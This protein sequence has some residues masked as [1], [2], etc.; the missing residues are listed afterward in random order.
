MRQAAGHGNFV[1]RRVS[2][3]KKRMKNSVSAVGVLLALLVTGCQSNAGNNS[4]ETEALKTQIAQLEQQIADLERELAYVTEGRATAWRANQD[5][6]QELEETNYKLYQVRL[7]QV[8][9]PTAVCR[10]MWAA[11]AVRKRRTERV[12]Q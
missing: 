11:G 9:C 2:M 5:Y 1:E 6:K 3:R 10:R 8:R 12:M 7:R 4:A